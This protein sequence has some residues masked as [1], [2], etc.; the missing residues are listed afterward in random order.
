MR[1]EGA[2][3]AAGS[4]GLTVVRGDAVEHI[5]VPE[6]YAPS[7]PQRELSFAEIIAF[8]APQY[9]LPEQLNRWR[10]SNVKN[11]W[12]GARRVL[13]ARALNLP[14][15]YGSLFLDV[16]RG[17]G[18][19]QSLGLVSMRVVTDAGVAYLTADMDNA[20][21]SSDIS[22]FKFH[23]F[24]TGTTAE[25][26]SQT[27]LITELTT[28]YVVNSTRPTGSQAHSTNTYT[29]VA[30]LAPDSGGVLAITEHGVFT[31][32]AAGTLWD[33]SKFAAVNLDSGN[34]DSLIA[35]YVATFPAGS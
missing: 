25:A 30:T 32:N 22:L 18:K 17:S 13:A 27:G 35:T 8:G 4:L 31:A 28:E 29:T 15:M 12:R 33:R 21:G 34:G 11:L 2:V 6:P 9:G 10:R 1:T 24:G 5:E 16:V 14:T 3:A 20:S 26:A 7:W 19:V 23:G